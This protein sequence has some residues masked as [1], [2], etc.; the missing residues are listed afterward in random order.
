MSYTS[1]SDESLIGRHARGDATAFELLYRRHEMR[2]WRYLQHNVGHRARADELM[3][4]LWFAVAKDGV[5]FQPTVRFATWLYSI[6]YARISDSV[7]PSEPAAVGGEQPIVISRALGQ[8]S[9]ERRSAFLLQMEG[10]LGIEE[11]AA[12]TNSSLEGIRGHLHQARLELHGLLREVTSAG[13]QQTELEDVDNRYRRASASEPGRPSEWVR[14]KVLAHAAQVAAEQAIKSASSGYATR[15]N[16]PRQEPEERARPRFA[17]WGAVGAMAVGG[18]FVAWHF[19][20]SR[21]LAELPVAPPRASNSDVAARPG[22]GTRASGG[23]AELRPSA[24][25]PAAQAA[26][27]DVAVVTQNADLQPPAGAGAASQ[28][29]MSSDPVG[30]RLPA[31]AVEGGEIGKPRQI[32][33]VSQ[34]S[35]QAP[36]AS[37][38]SSAAAVASSE[39]ASAS[40]GSRQQP[41]AAIKSRIARRTAVFAQGSS[42]MSGSPESQVRSTAGSRLALQSAPA[43]SDAQGSLTTPPV[44]G[45][46]PKVNSMGAAMPL[47][48]SPAPVALASAAGVTTALA[49]DAAMAES[50]STTDGAGDTVTSPQSSPSALWRA[51]QAGDI[52]GL[53]TAFAGHVDLNSRNSEGRTALMLAVR[54]GQ[55]KAVREL[56]AHGADPN[57]A[58]GHGTTP[59]RAAA[60]AGNYPIVAALKH[61]G[62]Q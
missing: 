22:A 12:I 18:L 34:A 61:A 55:A 58:D 45:S 40:E 36:L 31:S 57:V 50:T 17:L 2:T 1:D 62:A 8:L 20:I 26:S 37:P 5:R 60:A 28:V 13:D 51:A 10:E 32:A 3:Q 33:S 47:S 59:L 4:N 35:G 56:L 7:G 6:A 39:P 24:Q 9:P 16:S 53:Q 54:N 49:S 14:R 21:E 29:A 38:S 27:S 15:G 25:A 48:P 52:R 42:S 41:P 44:S 30:T 19:W 46:V 11:I 23:G 43:R